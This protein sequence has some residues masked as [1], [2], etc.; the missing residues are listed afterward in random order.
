MNRTPKQVFFPFTPSRINIKGKLSRGSV[1]NCDY[2]FKPHSKRA[3]GDHLLI[4]KEQKTIQTG[5]QSWETF[6][7][8][9]YYLHKGSLLTTRA[10]ENTAGAIDIQVLI[11]SFYGKRHWWDTWDIWALTIWERLWCECTFMSV[12]CPPH[13]QSAPCW[14]WA[15]GKYEQKLPQ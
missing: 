4:Q 13:T 3:Q 1:S 14:T 7:K 5:N 9:A 10:I 6:P 15:G 12:L 8:K 2:P 11:L